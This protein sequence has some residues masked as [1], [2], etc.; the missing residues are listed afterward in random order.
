MAA[1]N[2]KVVN[3]LGSPATKFYRALILPRSDYKTPKPATRVSY[4]GAGSIITRQSSSHRDISAF[5]IKFQSCTS[6][7]HYDINKIIV[8][9]LIGHTLDYGLLHR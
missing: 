3:E 9:A 6:T 1:Y 7:F 2:D 8:C 5:T 4:S